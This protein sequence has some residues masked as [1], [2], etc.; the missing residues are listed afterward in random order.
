MITIS[1][2]LAGRGGHGLGRLG[3]TDSALALAV[4]P[5]A[6]QKEMGCVTVRYG[7]RSSEP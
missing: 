3:T 5:R 6:R 7:A 4:S 1:L 2:S